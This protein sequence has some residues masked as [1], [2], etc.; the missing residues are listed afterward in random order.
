[1]KSLEDWKKEHEVQ[2]EPK[3]ETESLVLKSPDEMTDEELDQAMDQT[4]KMEDW[5]KAVQKK[6]YA[7]AMDGMKFTNFKLVR[8][9]TNRKISNESAV[10][11]TLEAE[12]F[13]P[14]MIA[15]KKLITLSALEKMVGKAQFDSLCGEYI[16]KPQGKLQLVPADDKRKKV[17]L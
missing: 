10:I 14:E 13:D 3:A 9:R 16:T 4:E 2:E 8:A 6:A 7:K 5:I 1:M 15:P 11:Q 12:G 17:K